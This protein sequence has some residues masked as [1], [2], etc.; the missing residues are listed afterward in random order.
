MSLAIPLMG[1]RQKRNEQLLQSQANKMTDT[2]LMGLEKTNKTT[3]IFQGMNEPDRT[4]LS[5]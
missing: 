3:E 4:L 5:V 2:Q 1:T